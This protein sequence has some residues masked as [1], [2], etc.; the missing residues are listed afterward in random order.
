MLSIYYLVSNLYLKNNNIYKIDSIIQEIYNLRSK[1]KVTKVSLQAVNT[2]YTEH[3][4][5][6]LNRQ[7]S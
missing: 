3:R 4:N 1:M 6:Q 5:G 7:T 2:H